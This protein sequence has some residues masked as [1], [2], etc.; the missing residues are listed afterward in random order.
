MQFNGKPTIR[1]TRTATRAPTA[2]YSEFQ[3]VSVF[4]AVQTVADDNDPDVLK[5]CSTSTRKP[6]SI[7]M[8]RSYANIINISGTKL[9]KYVTN[10]LM[11][12]RCR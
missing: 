12:K 7:K 6:I 1:T 10:Q 9:L 8:D 5:E 11:E 4:N 3:P 2:T